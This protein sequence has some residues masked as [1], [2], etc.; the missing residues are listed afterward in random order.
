MLGDKSRVNVLIQGR[1]RA[2]M[3][4]S[5]SRPARILGG[6]LVILFRLLSRGR[7]QGLCV[8]MFVEVR[9][10]RRL[11]KNLL[12]EKMWEQHYR[13]RQDWRLVLGIGKMR[14]ALFLRSDVVFAIP[15]TRLFTRGPQSIVGCVEQRLGRRCC[16]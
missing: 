7:P 14:D 16:R 3:Q 5:W 15:L 11:R 10:V 9:E 1:G 8:L 2:A 12:C 4:Y 6:V 13:K